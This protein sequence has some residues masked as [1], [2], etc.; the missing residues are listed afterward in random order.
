MSDA[1]GDPDDRTPGPTR[2]P[3]T[4]LVGAVGAVAVLVAG[5]VTFLVLRDDGRSTVPGDDLEEDAE[6]ARVPTS[7]EVPALLL[8]ADDPGPE[9]FGGSFG[10]PDL[11]EPGPELV[12]AVAAQMDQAEVDV[13]TGALVADGAAPGLYGGSRRNRVCD[14]GAIADFLELETQKGEAFAEVLGIDPVGILDALGNLAAVVLVRDTWVTD[15]AYL[16]GETIPYQA[17]LQ[18]GTAVL[19]DPTGVPRVRCTSGD[20]LGAPE[21]E[22]RSVDD[23]DGDE[24][25]GFDPARVTRIEAGPDQQ[26]LT[27]LDIETGEQLER[28]VGEALTGEVTVTLRWTGDADLDLRVFDPDGEETY[29]ALPVSPSGGELIE[30]VRPECGDDPAPHSETVRWEPGTAPFGVYEAVVEVFAACSAADIEFEIE[31]VVDGVTQLLVESTVAADGTSEP[32]T[33]VR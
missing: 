17:I 7:E 18:S 22:G 31:V 3:P 29:H 16:D 1:P 19:V 21:V 12:A 11:P 27:L 10:D 14:V 2:R 25:D 13:D 33:A 4:W 5:A 24:W 9:P 15:H 32:F 30:D 26:T 8:A 6:D 28:A 23:V 20:P